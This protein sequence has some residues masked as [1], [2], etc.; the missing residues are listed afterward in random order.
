MKNGG[1]VAALAVYGE[2]EVIFFSGAGQMVRRRV[3][4]IPAR[5]D[6]KLVSLE[7]ADQIR[8]IA[9]VM[10]DQLNAGLE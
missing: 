2:D 7:G 5:A 4:S 6:A 8:A 1:V 9:R 3:S 10:D